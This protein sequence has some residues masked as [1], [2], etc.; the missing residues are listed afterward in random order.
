[1]IHAPLAERSEA[2]GLSHQ[3]AVDLLQRCCFDVPT[4]VSKDS[5]KVIH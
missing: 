5:N 2:S 3:H 4:L 1:M